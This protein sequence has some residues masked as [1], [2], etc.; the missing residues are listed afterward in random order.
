MRVG[1]ALFAMLWLT[2]TAM[3][4]EPRYRPAVG[5]IATFRT[6]YTVR[7]G[8]NETVFGQLY[9][10]TTT[11]SSDTTFEATLTPLALLFRCPAGETQKNCQQAP[12]YPDITRDGDMITVP[13]PPG[14]SANLAKIG[15]VTGRD[16]IRTSQVFP[17]PGAENIEETAKPRIGATALFVQTNA[18]DCAD[19]AI[20]A[21]FPLGAMATLSVPCKVT[22]E[23]SQSRWDLLKDMSSSED[24]TYDLSF[25]GRD[26]IAVPA[27]DFDVALV[28]YKV[29]PQGQAGPTIEGDWEVLE[30]I[31]LTA[32]TAVLVHLPN[33]T[34]T[35]HVLRELIKLGS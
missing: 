33:S 7:I 30:N 4:D 8:G 5:T 9:R 13:I 31:G 17:I 3:A 34:N 20:K 23:R 22:S 15:K 18:L 29:T 19:A 26:H 6:L 25:A 35:S 28:K 21:F 16:F 11:A 12:N 14:I 24:A 32:R 2:A 27:G 1:A 10:L